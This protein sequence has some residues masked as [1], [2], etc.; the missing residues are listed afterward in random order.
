MGVSAAGF[1]IEF[2]SLAHSF[3]KSQGFLVIQLQWVVK[4]NNTLRPNII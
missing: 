1:V 4:A 2:S 3:S